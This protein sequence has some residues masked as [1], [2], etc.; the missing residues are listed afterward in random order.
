M[1]CMIFGGRYAI[2]GVDTR[3]DK[4]KAV[5]R[6][7]EVNAGDESGDACGEEWEGEYDGEGE[8]VV[9]V[10]IA[11]SVLGDCCASWFAISVSGSLPAV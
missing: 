6:I 1:L 7:G 10:Y 4:W 5:F 8:A 11:I 3:G 9:E 2:C